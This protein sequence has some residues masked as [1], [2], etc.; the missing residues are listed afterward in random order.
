MQL[1]VIDTGKNTATE[2]MSIDQELLFSLQAH[3]RPI[4]HLY[5]WSSP[6]AT[7]GYFSNPWPYLAKEALIK[8]GI[9][10]AKRPTGG[11]LIFHQFDLAFSFLLPATH[12]CFSLNTLANYSL[13][14]SLVAE[15]VRPFLAK[16]PT[17]EQKTA[18]TPKSPLSSF[19]MASVTI[20]DVVIAGRKIAGAA[21]RRT[22]HGLLHQGSI[23]LLEAPSLFLADIFLPGLPFFRSHTKKWLSNFSR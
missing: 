15:V 7:Y 17:L 21:Q 5:D 1:E 4:L 9:Q 18:S 11:G 23:C 16:R 12:A 20:Y 2:N 3:P 14:N 6:S 19:C 13:V 8:W 22:S 10:L